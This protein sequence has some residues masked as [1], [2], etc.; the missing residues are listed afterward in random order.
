MLND[1]YTDFYFNEKHS[2]DMKVWIT[3]SNDLSIS[4][5]PTFKDST[6]TLASGDGYI[7]SGSQN[8][9]TTK[10][11]Q[12]VAINVTLGE[13]RKICDWLSPNIIGRLRFDFNINSYYVV[14]LST[15]PTPTIVPYK[16]GT[17]IIT[18]TLSFTTVGEPYA[19][20]ST[21]GAYLNTTENT[22][23]SSLEPYF[24]PL[25]YYVGAKAEQNIGVIPV[26]ISNSVV[27]VSFQTFEPSLTEIDICEITAY[28]SEPITIAVVV[29]DDIIKFGVREEGIFKESNIFVDSTI[30]TTKREGEVENSY[31][32][33][34][35][36]DIVC[37][38]NLA[39]IRKI[40]DNPSLVV[41]RKAEPSYNAVFNTGEINGN[42]QLVVLSKETDSKIVVSKDNTDNI[43]SLLNF[44]VV[45]D[46]DYA[47]NFDYKNNV[48]TINGS[49]LGS[50]G[51]NSGINILD[52]NSLSFTNTLELESGE[53][54]ILKGKFIAE[55]V[56]S[57]GFYEYRIKLEKPLLY[58]NR[59]NENEY[60]IHIFEISGEMGYNISIY[61]E[62][63][64]TPNIET[65]KILLNP[66][67][68]VDDSDNTIVDLITEEDLGS[69]IV[70]DHYY[71]F[72][73]CNYDKIRVT[74]D[75]EG[76]EIIED[77]NIIFTP[78]GV[79]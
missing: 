14:K 16:E 37:N 12:C 74:K 5:G 33:S 11:M 27:G 8:L 70:L 65:Q 25:S 76:Q 55:P 31:I 13:W 52:P 51:D 62:G 20:Y 59:Q 22:E 9:A 35:S 21:V 4:F 43:V 3:N 49:L 40:S 2:T 58:P 66:G 39:K 78:R 26:S 17:Y 57:S 38:N 54:E 64:L 48:I 18:F 77:V 75:E 34:F 46:S 45:G 24:F 47:V 60:G 23:Y 29:E 73:I 19:L 36:F 28:E 71:N 30:Y 10:K 1:K 42:P 50:I 61:G 56:V 67:L 69:W 6:S 32:K 79:I 7:F 68:R 44:N 53:P 41:I 63:I 72:S 15:I